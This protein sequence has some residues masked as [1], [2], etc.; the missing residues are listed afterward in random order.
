MLLSIPYKDPCDCISSARLIQ[1][2]I[3]IPTFL[4]TH[5]KSLLPYNITCSQFWRIRI[6]TSLGTLFWLPSV[7]IYFFITTWFLCIPKKFVTWIIWV[8]SGEVE[9]MGDCEK[10][11][12]Y[13]TRNW[14]YNGIQKYLFPH[15]AQNSS[16][17]TLILIITVT[18][19]YW[20]LYFIPSTFNLH[21]DPLR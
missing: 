20:V 1:G 9:R 13:C 8:D 12:I 2:N 11:Y 3:S 15:V 4:I 21:P 7:S 10:M 6:W 14:G 17:K 18:H 5:A 19:I 16:V